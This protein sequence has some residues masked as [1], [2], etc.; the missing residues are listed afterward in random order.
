MTKKIKIITT[1]DGSHSLYVP[2]LKETYHSTHGAWQESQHVFIKHGLDFILQNKAL[3]KL[4]IL[5]IGFGTG[6]NAILTLQSALDSKI[7]I[8]YHTLEPFPLDLELINQ[9]NYGEFIKEEALIEAFYKMHE[10]EWQAVIPIT[11]N[12]SIVKHQTK[13]EDF[14]TNVK[15]DLVY[16]DAFAPSKQAELWTLEMIQKVSDMMSEGGVLVTYCAKGQFKR[17]LRAVGLEV[18]TLPGPPGKKEM[19]RGVFQSSVDSQQ[20]SDL[21]KTV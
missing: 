8:E 16:Y 15:F 20:F 6:L 7:Q 19:V 12:F 21:S 11:E 10:S 17:D 14:K 3:K 2:D 13:L 1:D 18:E 9:L 5:E 4:N